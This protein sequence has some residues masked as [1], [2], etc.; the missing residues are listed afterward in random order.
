MDRDTA[1]VT[2][3]KEIVRSRKVLLDEQVKV[4][5]SGSEGSIA[6]ARIEWL[7]A[8]LELEREQPGA[9]APFLREGQ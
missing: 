1:V 5:G 2:I 9:S 3:L 4:G 8:I 6:Q 7:Q